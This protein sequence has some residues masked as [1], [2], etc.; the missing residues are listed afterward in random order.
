MSAKAENKRLNLLIDTADAKR[1]IARAAVREFCKTW[2]RNDLGRGDKRWL[3]LLRIDG[4]PGLRRRLSNKDIADFFKVYQVSRGFPVTQRT[5]LIKIMES[6]AI[7]NPTDARLLAEAWKSAGVTKSVNTS[8]ASKALFFM[9]PDRECVIY[10]SKAALAIETRYG[11]NPENDFDKF[12]TKVL[13]RDRELQ[14]FWK[15]YMPKIKYVSS[16]FISRRLTDKY[17]F[18]EGVLLQAQADVEKS[19][20]SFGKW[21]FMLK[22]EGFIQSILKEE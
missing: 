9:R 12:R 16:C 13:E 17:L 8:A 1:K 3:D 4:G 7:K 21:G 20:K 14:A 6:C 15:L 18:I 10:D 22:G 5:S 19:I 11:I 2:R